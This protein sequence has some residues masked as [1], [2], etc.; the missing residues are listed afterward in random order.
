M[1]D[2]NFLSTS[3]LSSSDF[4]IA[5]WVEDL[6]TVPAAVKSWAQKVLC[7]KAKATRGVSSASPPK[8]PLAP[9]GKL[10]PALPDVS[11]ETFYITTAINYVS[12][13]SLRHM[14]IA[15]YV[16]SQSLQTPNPALRRMGDLI[17]DMHTRL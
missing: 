1:L 7:M 13:F 3:G 12:S 6:G 4:V 16:R 15:P 11:K 9:K 2:G 10:P 5:A 8:K 17:V 14:Y